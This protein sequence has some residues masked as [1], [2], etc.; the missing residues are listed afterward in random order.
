MDSVLLG[1][2][3]IGLLI[4]LVM[5]P[6]VVAPAQPREAC[7]LE[8]RGQGGCLLVLLCLLAVAVCM[9]LALCLL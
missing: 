9:L 6:P 4:A 3:I 8:P 1:L 2:V 7:Q 5:R